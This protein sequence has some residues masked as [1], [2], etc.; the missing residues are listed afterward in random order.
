MSFLNM[1]KRKKRHVLCN[2]LKECVVIRK[3]IYVLF[4]EPYKIYIV[5]T[6]YLSFSS[7]HGQN[8]SITQ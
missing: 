2:V 3:K 4:A 5:S 7:S 8:Q 1:Y 6:H